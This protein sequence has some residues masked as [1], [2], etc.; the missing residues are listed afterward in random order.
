MSSKMKH[1][2]LFVI[3]FATV[4]CSS[5]HQEDP[6]HTVQ[7]KEVSEDIKLPLNLFKEFEKEI[8]EEFKSISPVFIFMP[9]QVRFAELPSGRGVLKDTALQFN[10]E[11]GGGKVDLKDVVSS[12]GS[13]YMH[14]PAE[15]FFSTLEVVH[16]YY[17]SQ[18]PVRKIQGESFGLGCGKWI[19]LKQSFKKLTTPNALKFNTT[20][21]RHLHVLAGHFVFVLKQG[22]QIYLSQL[23]ITDSRYS[24]QLCTSVGEIE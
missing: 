17:I 20:M 1:F 7:V 18:S 11:K 23:T 6:V 5:P 12:Q 16:A 13:F 8:A 4:A 14:F 19:D 3:G 10:F 15:Q 24:R 21:Q 22:H 9:L 2:I